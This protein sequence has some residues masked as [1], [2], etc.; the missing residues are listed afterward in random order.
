MVHK[1][2]I[3]FRSVEFSSQDLLYY[4]AELYCEFYNKVERVSNNRLYSGNIKL[5]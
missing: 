4:D 3:G 5:K 1:F 2:S